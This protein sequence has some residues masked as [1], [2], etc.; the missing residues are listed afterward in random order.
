MFA[1]ECF[2]IF[3]WKIALCLPFT[4]ASISARLKGR[5]KESEREEK[6]EKVAT[7]RK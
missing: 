1:F 5:E 3:R 6:R 4:T 2:A 7:R